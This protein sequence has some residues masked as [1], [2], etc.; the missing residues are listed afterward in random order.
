MYADMLEKIIPDFREDAPLERHLIEQRFWMMGENVRIPECITDP[1][2]STKPDP[3]AT[4]SSARSSTS[5]SP[6]KVREAGA[7]RADRKPRR[8]S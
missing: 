7:H 8:L 2:I 5:G 3:I 6:R 1:T 4:P